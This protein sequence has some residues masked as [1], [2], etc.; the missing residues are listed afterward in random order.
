M[1]RHY[2]PGENLLTDLVS[3]AVAVGVG[4]GLTSWAKNS[5]K[6]GLILGTTAGL[7]VVGI[8]GKHL[9]REGMLHETFE[10]IGYVGLGNVGNWAAE[11]TTTFGNKAP[12]APAFFQTGKTSS[13]S[14]AAQ[15]AALARSRGASQANLVQPIESRNPNPRP[16]ST[17]QYN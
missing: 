16:T 1:R 5:N 12:G 9:V 6:Q 4:Y 17:Y 7:G 2:H 13:A 3:G 15:R 14:I 11:A 8:G 10:A